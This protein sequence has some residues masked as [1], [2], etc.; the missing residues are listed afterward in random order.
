ME[1]NSEIAQH[2][3]NKSDFNFV[4]MHP[5]NHFCDH[6]SQLGNNFNACSELPDRVIMD[7]KQ[8]Y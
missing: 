4:K 2:E 8:A 3:V 7:L 6:I 1:I 5:V